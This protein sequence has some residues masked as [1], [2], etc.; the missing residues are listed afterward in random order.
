MGFLQ[1][2]APIIF[3][4]FAIAK[5]KMSNNEPLYFCYHVLFSSDGNN[6]TYADLQL[7]LNSFS[8]EFLYSFKIVA[9]LVKSRLKRLGRAN[10]DDYN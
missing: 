1:D 6:K 4:L 2:S 7:T 3:S 5:V 10:A 9:K 8:L